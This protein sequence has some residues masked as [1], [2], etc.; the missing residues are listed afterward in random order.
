MQA[1]ATR[2]LVV[3]KV[4]KPLW[5]A[6][7]GKSEGGSV[8]GNVIHQRVGLSLSWLECPSTLNDGDD[9]RCRFFAG[10]IF[11]W[12]FARRAW[13]EK[14]AWLSVWILLLYPEAVLLGSSQMREAFFIVLVS[15]AFYGLVRFR[16]EHDLTGICWGLVPLLY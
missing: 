4:R 10:S 2:H 14:I 5:T 6:F 12:A 1:H 11:T 13:N 3:S 16:E 15:A 8:R 9:Y 7:R